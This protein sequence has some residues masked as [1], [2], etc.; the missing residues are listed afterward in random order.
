MPQNRT[1]R[2]TS[3][4]VREAL[5]SAIASWLGT[6]GDDALSGIAFCD[7]YSGSGAVALEA[8]SRGATP[9]IAV[10]KD[11]LTA[12]VARRNAQQTRLPVQ[13]VTASAE[14][15]VGQPPPFGIRGFDVVWLDPPYPLPNDAVESVLASLVHNDW[16]VANALVVVE[17]SSRTSPFIWPDRLSD[18]WLRR[19]GETTLF[20]AQRGDE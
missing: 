2:P 13:V 4:R 11:R 5:F 20:F 8:A 15:V 9:V 17:R 18:A 14:V 6:T 10:E 12:D 1:T 7:L 3:D 19:Y 16:L